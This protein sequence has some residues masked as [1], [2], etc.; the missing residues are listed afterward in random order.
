MRLDLVSDINR[1]Y[2]DA[3]NYPRVDRFMIKI[4][5]WHFGFTVLLAVAS[6]YLRLSAWFPTP[7]AWRVLSVDEASS[8]AVIGL[9]AAAIPTL[10]RGRIGNHYVWRLIMSAALTTYSYVFVFL[11]GGSIE[12]HFHFFMVMALITVYSDW[13]LGWFVTV[14]TALHH[15]ILNYVSP[16][17]VYFY[18]RNDLAVVAHI[19]PVASTAVFTTLLCVNHRRSVATAQTALEQL[20]ERTAALQRSE[21][22]LAQAQRLTHAGSWAWNIEPRQVVHSSQEFYRVLGFDPDGGLPPFEQV[23]QRVHPEDRDRFV[24]AIER[25]IRERTIVE[26][27]HRVVLPDGTVKYAHHVGHPVFNTS[28]DLIQFVGSTLDVTDR[29]RAEQERE[30]LQ[31]D[32]AHVSRVTTMGELTASLAHEIKQ[33]ITAAVTNA[34]TCLRW[35]ARDDPD[36]AEAR[37]AASR[38]VKDTAQAVDIISRIGSLFKRG[39]PVRELIDI[40]D[41]IQSIIALLRHEADR[42]SISIR[43]ELAAELPQVLADRVLL[44]QVFM[45]LMLNGIDAMHT[46]TAAGE[47]TIT[48]ERAENGH[49]LV[50]VSD[51]GA[52]VPLHLVDHIF[53]A[54]FTTKPYGTGMGLPI[55]RSIVESHGGRLWVTAN[56]GRGATFHFTLPSDVGAS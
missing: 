39:A 10:I 36:V 56:S 54:F 35:L 55:S 43:A 29:K 23:L 17:W 46:L 45:N 18:G 7:F 8:A 38:M 6:S 37:E 14:L 28:G 12:M 11:S 9:L 27:D 22:Y 51:T 5:W 2:A 19:I 16:T 1:E 26:V 31:A 4:L 13:R 33:P 53:N 15:V 32:L 47:L 21:T 3:M 48:S 44:Q 34:K 52:G 40:N 24:G 49:L 50:S 42:Y 20:A 41:V 30:R 25:A